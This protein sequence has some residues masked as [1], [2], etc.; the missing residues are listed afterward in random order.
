MFFWPA[1]PKEALEWAWGFTA[2]MRR[3]I[4]VLLAL[5]LAGCL[6]HGGH[7]LP[8][9]PDTYSVS[10]ASTSFTQSKEASLAESNEY[11]ASQHK[12]ILVTNTQSNV[13]NQGG[14][15]STVGI[16]TQT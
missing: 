3:A 15:S 6:T 5:A 12:Q 9:G 11:C 10:Q 16:A 14:S 8:I 7:V 13:L 4:C 1:P 2:M